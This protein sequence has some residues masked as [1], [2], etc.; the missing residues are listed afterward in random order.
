M[1]I[2]ALLTLTRTQR[3]AIAGNTGNRKP[4]P[5]AGSENSRNVQQPLTAH[6]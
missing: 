5:N 6:S 2:K 3:T 4:F 1:P